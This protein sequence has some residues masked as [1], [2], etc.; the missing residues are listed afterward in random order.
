MDASL[1]LEQREPLASVDLRG[2]QDDV[3][4][5]DKVP[6]ST[7]QAH[8]LYCCHVLSTWNARVYEFAAVSGA[9]QIAS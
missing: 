5:Q 3:G 6:F 1:E 7:A 2:Q 4:D 8:A 9:N